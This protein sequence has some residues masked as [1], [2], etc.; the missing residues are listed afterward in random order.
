MKHYHNTNAE[1]GQTLAK[2]EAKARTQEEAI[3]AYFQAHP[4][5]SLSPAF[6]G[7]NVLPNAPLT[8]IRRAMTNLAGEG[9]LEKT[10]VMTMGTFGKHVHTWR[11]KRKAEMLF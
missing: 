4:S 7:L 6:V 5:D 10:D 9:K 11:L 2:S 8:S 1:S 3:L